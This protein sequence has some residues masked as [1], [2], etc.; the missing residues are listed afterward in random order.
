MATVL[1]LYSKRMDWDC[2][3]NVKKQLYWLYATDVLSHNTP[4]HSR[5]PST[6]IVSDGRCT[7]A[8][9]SLRVSEALFSFLINQEKQMH[10]RLVHPVLQTWHKQDKKNK[11]N[12]IKKTLC[13]LTAPVLLLLVPPAVSRY[14]WSQSKLPLYCI[15]L[16][17][18]TLKTHY[19][20][21]L[22]PLQSQVLYYNLTYCVTLLIRELL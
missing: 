16:D 5:V 22:Q 2:P 6:Y 9:S 8:A 15:P 1:L 10:K 3:K 14:P 21:I 13:F 18:N 12:R 7:Q 4:L 20:A 17:R 11:K 19:A